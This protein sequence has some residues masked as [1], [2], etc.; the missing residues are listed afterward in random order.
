MPAGPGA[1]ATLQV[2][3]FAL[4]LTT[5]PVTGFHAVLNFSQLQTLIP[6]VYK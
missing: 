5:G 6:I 1:S 2:S 4:P 3:T